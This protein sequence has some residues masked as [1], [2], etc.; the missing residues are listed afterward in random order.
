MHRCKYK[1]LYISNYIY[2]IHYRKTSRSQPWPASLL[3]HFFKHFLTCVWYVNSHKSKS[4][5]NIWQ[6]HL[7]KENPLKVHLMLPNDILPW[8]CSLVCTSQTFKGI[9]CDLGDVFAAA[10]LVI[11]QYRVQEF[12]G[13]CICK[14]VF[15][16][17]GSFY[18]QQ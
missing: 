15:V 8:S 1:S 12:M 16:G 5:R 9:F 3:K 7:L 6:P 11:T 4:V 13:M 2:Y 18:H 10:A 14:N 17:Q